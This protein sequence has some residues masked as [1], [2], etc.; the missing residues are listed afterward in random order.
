MWL[1]NNSTDAATGKQWAWCNLTFVPTIMWYL[2]PPVLYHEDHMS[3]ILA[4]AFV[5][6][7]PCVSDSLEER[8]VLKW[9]NWLTS[10]FF[11]R[12]LD[13][14]ATETYAILKEVLY[15]NYYHS[16]KLFTGWSRS[17]GEEK[18]PKTM[19]DLED[20]EP[21]KWTQTFK[22]WSIDERKPFSESPSFCW[23]YSNR[24]KKRS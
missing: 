8:Y 13:K 18:W 14:I 5:R 17:K 7:E 20:T 22:N 16:L 19:R 24:Q 15:M 3:L 2:P 4:V 9:S 12:F 10:S 6:N 23:V 1:L 11:V 21:Q